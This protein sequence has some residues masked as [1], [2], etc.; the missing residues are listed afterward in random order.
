MYDQ[1]IMCLL[2]GLIGHVIVCARERER[3]QKYGVAITTCVNIYMRV[4]CL[5]SARGCQRRSKGEIHDMQD[6]TG[7]H[8]HSLN[9]A[10]L[11][12]MDIYVCT[13][14]H[15][16]IYIYIERERDLMYVDQCIT[17]RNAMI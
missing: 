17:I 3:E 13:T 11:R 4:C 8:T 5:N 16:H 10:G 9:H 14:I 6:K 15:I 2:L 12:V 1:A 7:Q